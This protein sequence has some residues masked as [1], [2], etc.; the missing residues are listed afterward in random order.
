MIKVLI[1]VVKFVSNRIGLNNRNSSNSPSSDPSR[2]IPT[3]K[4]SGKKAGGQNGH[5]GS[6]LRQIDVPYIV[7]LY[8]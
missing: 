2:L 5:T 1:L 6:T 7:G 3:R 8:L 4:K